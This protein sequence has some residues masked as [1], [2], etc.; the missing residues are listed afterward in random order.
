ME[1][2][3][4]DIEVTSNQLATPDE[5]DLFIC[6]EHNR[7]AAGYYARHAT[8]TKLSKKCNRILDSNSPMKLGEGQ[9]LIKRILIEWIKLKIRNTKNNGNIKTIIITN[10]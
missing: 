2:V 9:R 1:T 3:E 4:S 8:N 6:T 10:S 7:K 5:I